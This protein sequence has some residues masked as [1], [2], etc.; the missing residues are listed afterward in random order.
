MPDKVRMIFTHVKDDG[1]STA[2][3]HTVD[4]LAQNDELGNP[5]FR[6]NLLFR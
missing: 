4:E 2:T 6:G 1:S 3:E 5:I